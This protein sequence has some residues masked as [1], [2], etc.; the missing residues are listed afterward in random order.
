MDFSPE[1]LSSI[2]NLAAAR[3]S[4]LL[5]TPTIAHLADIQNALASLP[6][7]VPLS[8]LGTEHSLRFVRENILPGLAVGQAGPRYYGFVTGGVL[9]A[10]QAGDFLTTIYDQNSASS[11]AEQTVSAAV[12]DRTLEMVLDLFD[13]PCER[14]TARTLTTGATASNVLAMTCG[15]DY[16]VRIGTGNQEHSVAEDG[17]AGITVQVLCDRPHASI[18]KAAAIVGIGRSNVIDIG[19]PEG[20]GIDLDILETRISEYAASFERDRKVAF[21]VLSFGEV[22]T[23][24]FSPNVAEV[25]KICDKYNVWLHIDAAFGA[26]ARIIPELSSMAKHLELADSITSDGHKWFN[27]PYD[28]G[29]FFSRSLSLQKSI[30]GPSPKAPPPAYLAPAV[31][32]NAPPR[33]RE[34]EAAHAI[35]SGMVLG[36]ENS[37]RFRALPLFCALLAM[38][39]Q[40]YSELI[41]RNITF[42]RRIAEWM[43]TG[44]GS[45]W[46]RVLNVDTGAVPGT[47]DLNIVLFRAKSDCGAGVYAPENPSGSSTLVSAINETRKIYVTPSAGSDGVGAIRLAVSNWMTGLGDEFEV[48]TGVLEEVMVNARDGT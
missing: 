40:G 11:L 48:T 18:V 46:Y 28:C 12:E 43:H 27:V 5:T 26:F 33:T 44:P 41:S 1:T 39:K 22:N 25:R 29:L 35:P 3:P 17:F 16:A 23:G 36:I 38:G 14:F 20:K 32:P 19:S 13:L 10:A 45:K 15:R 6:E 2:L 30:F 24:E 4:D 8:G 47:I 34:L 42:A 9:P 31:N 7:S 37:R 21:V